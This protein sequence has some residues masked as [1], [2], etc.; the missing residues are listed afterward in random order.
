MS[1][2]KNSYSDNS[3]PVSRL[4][5]YIIGFVLSLITTLAAY[6]LVKFA[7]FPADTLIYVILGIAVVQFIVQLYFF[8]HIGSGSRW[9][10]VSFILALI[11]IL[12]V[13]IGTIWVMKNLD[14]NMMHMSPDEMQQYMEVN[15]GI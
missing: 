4:A 11:I 5:H 1:A 8:L 14:Y 6:F 7:V 9:K 2:S 3:E 13:V 12:I 10:M 15:Q